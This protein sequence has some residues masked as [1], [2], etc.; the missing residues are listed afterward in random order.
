M[1]V[2][3]IVPGQFHISFDRSVARTVSVQPRV[4][5]TLL[6][7][8]GITTVAASPSTITIVGPEQR[9]QAIQTAMTDPVDATGVVG[10]ATF[11]THAYVSDP[12]VRV[13]MPRPIHV[14]VNTGKVSSGEQ[15]G[16]EPG[17]DE[18][19]AA[20]I[21]DGWNSGSGGRVSPRPEDDVRDWA[22][23]G[24]TAG[25]PRRMMLASLI[26]QDTRE[27]SSW[28]SESWRRLGV[29]QSSGGQRRS[30]YYA[31]RRLSHPRR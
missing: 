20:I 9:V 31:G 14:T 6:S 11:T 7:G 10:E 24:A 29:G 15:A 19:H 13:R 22:R 4:I 23:P 17:C 28:I 1:T 18:I 5:G 21:W 2:V 8:Y 12:L 3:Q 27:S 30:Y 16:L 25:G 26:G